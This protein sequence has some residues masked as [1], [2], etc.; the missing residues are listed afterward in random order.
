[1]LFARKPIP[2]QRMKI[3]LAL[4]LLVAVALTVRYLVPVRAY[5]SDSDAVR[6]EFSTGTWEAGPPVKICSV[7]PCWG[8]A[9][10]CKWPVF[11]YGDGFAGEATAKLAKGTVTIVASK[12]WVLNRFTA[13]AVFDLRAAGEGLYDVRLDF[14]DGRSAVLSGGFKVVSW[15]SCGY[16]GA[17]AT[18]ATVMTSASFVDGPVALNMESTAPAAAQL[19]LVSGETPGG[20][21]GG[22]SDGMYPAADAVDMRYANRAYGPGGKGGGAGD[23]YDERKA[24]MEE[25][26]SWQKGADTRAR[27]SLVLAVAKGLKREVARAYAVAPGVLLEGRV[28]KGAGGRVSVVFDLSGAPPKDFDVVLLDP[29]DWP[30][31]L[32]G[33]ITPADVRAVTAPRATQP[34][35]PAAPLVGGGE[36]GGGAEA[37]LPGQEAPPAAEKTSPAVEEPSPAVEESPPT[38]EEPPPK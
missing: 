9:G 34:W 5:F 3:Y 18:S 11:I 17:S 38:V 19:V 23:V 7:C 24:W 2:K 30:L 6:G 20:T 25:G 35:L 15:G 36:A 28:E 33:M 22:C 14:A 27:G 16:V 4:L 37:P 1:M 31:L 21:S 32:E 8:L 13:Y 26:A 12:T 29:Q 10:A